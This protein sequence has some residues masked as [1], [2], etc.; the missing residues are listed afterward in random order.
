[1]GEGAI[2]NRYVELIFGSYVGFCVVNITGS[3]YEGGA[4]DRNLLR[5]AVGTKI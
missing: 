3:A 2:D 5:I 4:V 1:M